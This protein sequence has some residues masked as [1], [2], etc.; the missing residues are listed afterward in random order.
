MGEISDFSHYFSFWRERLSVL[1]G[2]Y[3]WACSAQIILLLGNELPREKAFYFDLLSK[4]FSRLGAQWWQVHVTV[5][6]H[7]LQPGLFPKPQAC[8][9]STYQFCLST[10]TGQRGKLLTGF[11][12]PSSMWFTCQ[13]NWMENLKILVLSLIYLT[14]FVGIWGRY[15]IVW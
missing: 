2:H 3:M 15:T 8:L 11:R 14:L 5:A 12:Q 9:F 4:R 13:E 1:I 10:C 6:S 7:V